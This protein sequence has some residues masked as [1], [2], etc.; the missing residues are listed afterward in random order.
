MTQRDPNFFWLCKVFIE[1]TNT[2][3]ALKEVENELNDN[4][5]IND[6]ALSQHKVLLTL[7]VT[8]W[9]Q[10]NCCVT[11]LAMPPSPPGFEASNIS[12]IN[13]SSI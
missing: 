11:F 6:V 3:N 2:D 4:E 1:D 8:K 10:A 12:Q 13:S 5:V 9:L 7:S